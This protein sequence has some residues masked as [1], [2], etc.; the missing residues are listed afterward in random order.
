LLDDDDDDDAMAI[1][2]GGGE[3]GG[4]EVAKMAG[5]K[6]PTLSIFSIS[7]FNIETI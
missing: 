5:R 3:V 1:V 2:D 7:N 6:E 4:K